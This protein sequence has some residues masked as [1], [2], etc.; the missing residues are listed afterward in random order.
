MKTAPSTT[1]LD[2]KD[3][4]SDALASEKLAAGNYSRF[5]DEAAT[6]KI[7][8][9]FLALLSEEH[10]IHDSLFQEMNKRGWYTPGEADKRQIEQVKRRFQNIG[11]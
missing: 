6:P 11:G 4:L 3:L 10:E 9:E 7:R 2:D 8:Q 1:Y 5:T